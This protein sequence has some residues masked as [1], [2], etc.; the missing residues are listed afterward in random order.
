M[1]C[2]VLHCT[3]RATKRVENTG[4][5]KVWEMCDEHAAGYNRDPMT[6]K[7]KIT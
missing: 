7:E 1:T 3:R 6:I 2:Q 5:G 4:T